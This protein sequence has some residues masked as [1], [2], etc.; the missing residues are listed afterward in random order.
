MEDRGGNLVIYLSPE[1]V[2]K[3]MVL[4]R[5]LQERTGRDFR[6]QSLFAWKDLGQ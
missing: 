3:L 1:D 4:E 2:Q 5:L 6:F